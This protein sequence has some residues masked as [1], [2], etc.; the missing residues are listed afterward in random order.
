MSSLKLIA[1]DDLPSTPQKANATIDQAQPLS[2]PIAVDGQVASL[3]RNYYKFAAE[4][5]QR[6]S[7][8]VLAR[9]MGSALDPLI[10]ILDAQ[11]RELTYSD[12]ALGLSA[13]AQLSYT[14]DAAGEYIVEVR[15]IRYQ[16]GANYRYRLRIGDFPCV[17]AP[18]PMGAKRGAEV[19]LSFAGSQVDDLEPL[20]VTVPDDPNIKWMP[21][22]GKRVGGQSSGFAVLTTGPRDEFLETEPNDQAG[23]SNRVTLTANL[24]GRFNRSGDVDRFVF[25]A[26]KAEKVRFSGITRS[27]ASPS[28]LYLVLF[29][30]EGK[31][32]AEAEDSAGGDGILDFTIPQD[33][34][35]TLVAQDLHRRG[36]SEFV[37][38]IEVTQPHSGFTLSAMA[39]NLNVPAGGVAAVTVNATRGGYKGPI[40]IKA[41][42]LPDGVN[43][44]PTVIGAG[45]TYAVL[46]LTG[47]ADAKAGKSFPVEIVGSARIGEN[48]Y[49]SSATVTAA[50]KTALAGMPYPPQVLA[51]ASALAVSPKPAFVLKTEPADIVFRRDLQATVKVTAERAEGFDEEITLALIPEKK[52]L[53]DGITAAVKPIPKGKNEIEIVFSATA[54]AP[55]GGFTGVLT[56]TLT[57]DKKKNIQPAPG[58]GLKLE[59]ALTISADAAGGKM[60]KG[61]QLKVKAVVKRNP[62]LSGPVAITFENL[63][64]GITA[65]AASIAADQTEVEILLAAAQDAEAGTV[66]NVIIKA[67]ATLGK[68]K[69]AAKSSPMALVVE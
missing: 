15:D 30:G 28:D 5:G 39:D 22:G 35:Y 20:T 52:G 38:R 12:D 19:Q 66:E 50:L 4:A 65:E 3:A 29:N 61:G 2:L 49:Q 18:Y 40:A 62:A 16:G 46:T 51:N 26:K 44:L 1:V 7:F 57:K 8:E 45:Q 17:T 64:K 27:Q 47:S 48:D 34:D 31:K 6:V 25:T 69:F 10:R 42:N 68:K 53:P 67:E 55:M 60:T 54:K 37:Y 11:G 58:I 32:V 33:G 9:R 63:P 41:V 59:E 43:S 21:V 56:G 36:G 13:D 23:Q 24:N 14:F